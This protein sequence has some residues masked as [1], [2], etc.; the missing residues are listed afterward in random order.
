M[1]RNDWLVMKITM[2]CVDWSVAAFVREFLLS[3][4][5]RVSVG[6]Q[7]SWEVRVTSGV[8]QGRVLGPLLFVAY[9]N[10][11]WRNAESTIK[12]SANDCVIYNNISKRR[13]RIVA[14]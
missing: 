8:P 10:G 5:Q 7:L 4:M 11:I 9:L 6:G 2:L 12:T 14:E 1:G 13:H 3:R